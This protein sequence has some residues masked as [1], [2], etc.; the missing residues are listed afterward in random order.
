MKYVLKLSKVIIFHWIGIRLLYYK[1]NSVTIFALNGSF[2]SGGFL[3]AWYWKGVVAPVSVNRISAFRPI[4]SLEMF[5]NLAR[6]S[7]LNFF[8][9][10]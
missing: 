1:Y 8:S 10:L 7:H 4:T 6:Y 9:V 3:L 5:T 2:L